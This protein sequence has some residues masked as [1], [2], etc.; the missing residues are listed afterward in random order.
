MSVLENDNFDDL[1]SLID[2]NNYDKKFKSLQKSLLYEVIFDFTKNEKETEKQIRKL[3]ILNELDLS[4]LQRD[5]LL[6]NLQRLEILKKNTDPLY[7]ATYLL[8]NNK[9]I[10]V[11][12][13]TKSVPCLALLDRASVL[14]SLKTIQDNFSYVKSIVTSEW[15]RSTALNMAKI[16]GFDP[17]DGDSLSFMTYNSQTTEKEKESYKFPF[18]GSSPNSFVLF[19]QILRKSKIDTR[20]IPSILQQMNE[21]L[22]KY[23]K[24]YIVKY[25]ISIQNYNK[26]DDDFIKKI[27]GIFVTGSCF[28]RQS[29]RGGKKKSLN[30]KTRKRKIV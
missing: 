14:S 20:E 24:W 2:K 1:F 16:S 5:N 3:I 9:N 19:N 11:L 25:G 4:L 10:P 21:Q 17:F 27:F 28:E 6:R 15:I 7:Q 18:P 23:F 8:Q 13:T 26:I 29:G 22:L 30:S 12:T